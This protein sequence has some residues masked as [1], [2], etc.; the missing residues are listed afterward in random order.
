MNM[1]KVIRNLVISAGLVLTSAWSLLGES[2]EKTAEH[3]GEARGILW[4]YLGN[5][6]FSAKYYVMLLLG[7]L[8][9]IILLRGKMNQRKLAVILLISLFLFGIAGNIPLSPFKL[10][11]M[12]P[13]PVCVTKAML[14]GLAIPMILMLTVIL[15]LSLIGPRI[16]CGYICPVGAIQELIRI[17][18]DRLKIRRIPFSF[19]LSQVFRVGFFIA[20][21]FLSAT[22][23]LHV[24]FKD[25]VVAVSLYDYINAFHGFE[26]SRPGNL[27]DG[28]T[29][30]LPLLL[31]IGLAF[32]FYRP[33]CHF[34]CPIGLFT[35]WVEPVALFRVAVDRK[36]CTDCNK[37]LKESPCRAIGDILN[38]STT[39]PDCFMCN[40]CIE[41]CP[42]KTVAVK[43]I[44]F[45]DH[46]QK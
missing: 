31:T 15:I 30:Y 10:F 29:Q 11:S 1:R 25:R 18:G 16:F 26:F 21:I 7:L 22:S 34:V 20:F 44:H 36:T 9:L 33:F 40:R 2:A 42:E 23:I 5:L 37:C 8:V 38:Q 28:L 19:V 14:Y 35:H 43:G 27:V 3:A 4:R 17:L 12:H 6:D 32:K 46:H 45:T 13:S 24:V 39:W 41:V